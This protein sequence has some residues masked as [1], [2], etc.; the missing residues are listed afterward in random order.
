[1]ILLIDNYDSFTFN[2]VHYLGGLGAKVAVYRNDK[3]SVVDALASELATATPQDEPP[4]DGTEGA[5]ASAPG[6][7]VQCSADRLLRFEAM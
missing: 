6:K 5:S 4:K 2:L 7:M 1:M 3:I